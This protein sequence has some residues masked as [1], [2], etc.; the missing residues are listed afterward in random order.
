MGR[1]RYGLLVTLCNVTH[2]RAEAARYEDFV[3]GTGMFLRNPA[4]KVPHKNGSALRQMAAG[5]T[6]AAS[7]ID[8][9]IL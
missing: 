8:I 6:L 5:R 1:S 2:E 3:R 7:K 4:S 9:T